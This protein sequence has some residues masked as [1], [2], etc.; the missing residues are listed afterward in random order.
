MSPLYSFI[1]VSLPAVTATDN[2]SPPDQGSALMGGN[3]HNPSYSPTDSV[4]GELQVSEV[5][6]SPNMETERQNLRSE[7]TM[8]TS[9]DSESEGTGHSGEDTSTGMGQ[10]HDVVDSNGESDND[11]GLHSDASMRSCVASD[12]AG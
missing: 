3:S 8:D 2:D 4:L 1:V 7:G 9:V 5:S 12:S 6:V 11:G 10:S